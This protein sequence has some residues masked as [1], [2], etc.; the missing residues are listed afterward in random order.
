MQGPS[1]MREDEKRWPKIAASY[2]KACQ[3]AYEKSLERGKKMD[4]R[5]GDDMYEWWITGK[6]PERQ[7]PDQT[8]FFFD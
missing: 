4:W 6:A 3:K 1:G 8:V 7:D 2:K 5:S